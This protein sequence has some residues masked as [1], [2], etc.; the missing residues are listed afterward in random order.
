MK[1]HSLQAIQ[2][3]LLI[4]WLVAP[5]LGI[6]IWV[7]TNFFYAAVFVIIW[8]I[9]DK[10]WDS[11]TELLIVGAG[12]VKAS[13]HEALQMVSSCEVPGRMAFMMLVDLFGTL[14]LPWVLAGI[15][16]GLFK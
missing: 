9:A 10:V 5:A 8:L 13:E 3:L 2:S 11:L 16:L 6:L 1:M 4:N 14:I 15:F 12:Q 7:R